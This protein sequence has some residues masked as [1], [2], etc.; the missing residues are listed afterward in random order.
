MP[1]NVNNLHVRFVADKVHRFGTELIKSQSSNDSSFKAA[2]RKRLESYLNAV[3]FAINWIESL[4]E[5]DLPETDPRTYACED[6]PAEVDAENEA[7]NVAV[8]ILRACWLETVNGQSARRAAGMSP[9]DIKRVRDV[10]SHCRNFLTEYV[11]NA[12]PLDLP[13]SSPVEA[14]TGPGRTG[15]NPGGN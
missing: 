1:V 4:P 15:I 6:F 5:L 8:D 2:D 9:H 3:D 13:E 10:V 12:L 14:N 7:I 11:T